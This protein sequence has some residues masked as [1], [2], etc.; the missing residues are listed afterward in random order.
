MLK[1]YKNT[2]NKDERKTG[3]RLVGHVTNHLH[4]L[5]VQEWYNGKIFFLSR[6]GVIHTTINIQ[7][8]CMEK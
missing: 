5:C 7:K 3:A 4:N 8:V 6:K 1:T 2:Q